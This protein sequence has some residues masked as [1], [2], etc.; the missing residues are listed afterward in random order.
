MVRITKYQLKLVKEKAGN[1][2]IDKKITTPETVK[3]AVN[4]ILNLNNEH[5]EKFGIL[6]L[7]TKNNI[8]GVHIISV[9]TLNSSLVHPREVFKAAILNNSASIILFHNH[10]SGD[11]TPSKE[12]IELTERLVEV[13]KIM[14]IKV[15]D[16][17]I[18]G[19]ENYCSLKEKGIF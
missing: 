11:C 13:G 16:H 6:A 19:D 4:E 17:I 14:G 12:D 9:G 8:I 15:L 5:V 2:N 1:Y 7:D 18:V 3:N 10:P